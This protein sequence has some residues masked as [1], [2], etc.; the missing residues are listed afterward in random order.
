[1]LTLA[2]GATEVVATI[3]APAPARAVL[4]AARVTAEGGT[5]TVFVIT[6]AVE[7]VAD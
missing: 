1:M 7:A 6:A 2:P 4:T 5:T 3:D